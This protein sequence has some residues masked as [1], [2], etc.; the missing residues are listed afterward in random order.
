MFILLETL[1]RA[2]KGSAKGKKQSHNS[3]AEDGDRVSMSETKM[4][5]QEVKGEL[6]S[7]RRSVSAPSSSTLK[8]PI[9]VSRPVTRSFLK[10]S[11]HDNEEVIL[12]DTTSEE[13]PE[14]IEGEE[15][16]VPYV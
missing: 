3:N 2:R 1:S 5:L 4:Q 13:W 10:Q 9:A 14:E 8:N 12:P 15:R 16:F 6:K 11:T 7:G